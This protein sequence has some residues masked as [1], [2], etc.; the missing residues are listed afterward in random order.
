MAYLL[1][2]YLKEN[3][4][5]FHDS[6]EAKFNS[7]KIFDRSYTPDDYKKILW[8]NYLFHLHFEEAAHGALSPETHAFLEIPARHKLSLLREDLV[9][10]NIIETQVSQDISIDDEAEALGIMYVM[11]G[12]TLGGNVIR[13]QLA[14]NP[15]FEGKEFRY[16]G[17]YGD[18]TGAFWNSFKEKLDTNVPAE[19]FGRVLAGTRKAYRFMMDCEIE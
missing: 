14:A 6:V 7:H 19:D 4:K 9:A 5:N 8:L 15:A 13:K 16:F 17:C 1:S 12:S 18:K 10:W 2:E 3:T 11:E